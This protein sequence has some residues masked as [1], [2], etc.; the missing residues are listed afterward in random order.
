MPLRKTPILLLG[1][2]R[3]NRIV[4]AVAATPAPTPNLGALPDVDFFRET[5]L[6]IQARA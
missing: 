1:L 4:L 2:A 3:Q 5:R 6:K